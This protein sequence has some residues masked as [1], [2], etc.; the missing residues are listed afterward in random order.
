[1]P[2]VVVQSVLLTFEFDEVKYSPL[3]QLFFFP[4]DPVFTATDLRVTK[5]PGYRS[6]SSR[7]NQGKFISS[8]ETKMILD[9]SYIDCEK[10][11]TF[12]ILGKILVSETSKRPKFLGDYISFSFFPVLYLYL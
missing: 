2:M 7:N 4:A 8:S 11:R 3:L 5:D 9:L 12:C 10:F 1:M 6:G